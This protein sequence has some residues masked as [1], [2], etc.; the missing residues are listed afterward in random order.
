MANRHLSRSIVLQTLFEWDFYNKKKGDLNTLTEKNIEEFGPGSSAADRSFISGLIDGISNKHK[1]LDEIIEK[2]AHDW[3]MDQTPLVDRNVIRI[4]LYELLFSNK[5]EV[6]ARVAINEAIELAKSFGGDRSGKFVNGVLGT[7]YKE[8]GEPGKNDPPKKRKRKEDLTPEEIENLPLHQKAGAV[9]Y[10]KGK[11]EPSFAFVHDVFG[12]W[13]LSKGGLEGNETPEE[14]V[15]REMKEEMNLD[16]KVEEGLG[17]NEYIANDPE[18]G[19]VRKRVTYF[20]AR[21]KKKSDIEVG[22]SGGLDDAKWFEVDEIDT[23]K[24]YEDIKK[25]INAGVAKVKKSK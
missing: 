23:M 20:L 11:G 25:I 24:T 5:E 14:A 12:N 19:K 15:I 9:V 1:T 16:V 10:Y 3:P 18:E 8:M 17:E 21:A 22:K 4:G 6:P 13:T 7:I 2:A